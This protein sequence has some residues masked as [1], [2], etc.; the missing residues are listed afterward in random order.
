MISSEAYKKHNRKFLEARLRHAEEIIVLY[1][2]WLLDSENEGLETRELVVIKRL[3]SD[4]QLSAYQTRR[5]ISG[6]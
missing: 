5:E 4:M 6:L 3:I 1:E 2:E